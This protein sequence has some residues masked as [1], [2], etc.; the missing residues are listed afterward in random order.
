MA[1][2]PTSR[3][4]LSD[5]GYAGYTNVPTATLTPLGQMQLSVSDVIPFSEATDTQESDNYAFSLGL[6]SRLEI[7]GRLLSGGAR[8]F[9]ANTDTRRFDGSAVR[10]LSTNLKLKIWSR[11]N[12]PT[13]SLGLRDASGTGRFAASYVVA[14]HRWRFLEATLGHGSQTLDGVFYGV[15]AD[16]GRYFSVAFDED[17]HQRTLLTE[18]ST[19]DVWRGARVFLRY[20]AL[21]SGRNADQGFGIGA[22][23]DLGQTRRWQRLG[24]T[25]PTAILDPVNVVSGL[26]QRGQWAQSRSHRANAGICSQPALAETATALGLELVAVSISDQGKTVAMSMD[27]RRYHQSAVDAAGVALGV[28]AVHCPESQK[29]VV[30][31]ARDGLPQ[32]WVSAPVQSL[33]EGLFIASGPSPEFEFALGRHADAPDV[34]WRKQAVA[35]VMLAPA[36]RY[37]LATEVGVLDYSLGAETTLRVPLWKGAVAFYEGVDEFASSDDF[38]D[39]RGDFRSFRL[40]STW[41]NRGIYQTLPLSRWGA[42]RAYYGRTQMFG[43]DSDLVSAELLLQPLQGSGLQLETRYFEAERRSDSLRAQEAMPEEVDSWTGTARYVWGAADAMLDLTWGRYQAD[44]EGGQVRLTRFFGDTSLELS[45]VRDRQK[46]NEAL[47]LGVGI[48][49]G[50]RRMVAMGPVAIG[51]RPNWSTTVQ[52]TINAR[53]NVIKPD[54]IRETILDESLSG[55]YFDRA[56]LT[57]GY[58]QSSWPRMRDTFLVY[59][60][61]LLVGKQ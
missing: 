34:P 59:A 48:P 28:I 52:T 8:G 38:A 1:A 33:R 9:S 26:E 58:V 16:L 39:R 17:T 53:Q 13:V 42:L 25:A 6:F 19:G 23:F 2:Y 15:R 51:A 41:F 32:F 40:P 56:R 31:V 44:D 3:P 22:T 57:R 7:G 12:Q 27:G 14:T 35:D 55:R 4:L 45:Y 54:L 21:A 61:K 10:D 5:S 30:Q 46:D 18:L 47:R 36:L 20:R 50:P 24:Y 11:P 29:A 43:F 37:G 49:F 60:Q